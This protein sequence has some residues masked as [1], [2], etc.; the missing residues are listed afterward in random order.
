M[1]RSVALILAG[2][3]GSRMNLS[4]PK[5]FVVVDGMTVL[6]DEA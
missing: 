5:Q 1:N 3:A 2:G 6:D 4:I